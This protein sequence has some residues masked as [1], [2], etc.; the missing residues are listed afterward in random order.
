M[1][2]FILLNSGVGWEFSGE[3]T[4]NL[5]NDSKMALAIDP[6]N[7]LAMSFLVFGINMQVYFAEQKTEQA[8]L[9]QRTRMRLKEL[10]EHNPN[11]YMTNLVRGAYHLSKLQTRYS[12]NEEDRNYLKYSKASLIAS[13]KGLKNGVSD[14]FLPFIHTTIMQYVADGQ[15]TNGNLSKGVQALSLIHI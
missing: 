1:L 15:I 12:I 14:I 8:I 7:I 2:N 6:D 5:E 11:H 9:F 10:V 3:S 13:E 4:K